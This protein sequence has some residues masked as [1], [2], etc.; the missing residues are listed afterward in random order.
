MSFPDASRVI[1]DKSPLEEVVCQVKFPA[2]LK[3]EAQEP[4]SFQERVRKE[5]PLLNEKS[6][7]ELPPGMPTEIAKLTLAQVPFRTGKPAYEFASADEQWTVNLTRDFL[8]LTSKKY[9]RWEGFKDHLATPMDALLS[10]YVPTFFSRIG[11]RYRD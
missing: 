11:L 8:A 6:P 3:I 4:V 9:K 7:I 10:E 2:I 1:Y 5:Y